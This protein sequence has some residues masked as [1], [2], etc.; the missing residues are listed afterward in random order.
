VVRRLMALIEP[1]FQEVTW[2]AFRGV[3]LDGETP[4]A[5]AA[6]LGISANAVLLAKSRILA[7]LRQEGQGLLDME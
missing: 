3:M 4:A 5:V 1:D 2:Q 6:R 7:R